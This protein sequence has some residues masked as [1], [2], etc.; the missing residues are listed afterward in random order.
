M[1]LV[2]HFMRIFFEVVK[3]P[4]R[5]CNNISLGS[6]VIRPWRI[7]TIDSV[8][9]YQ[10]VFLCSY[11]K[12]SRSPQIMCHMHPVPVVGFFSPVLFLFPIDGALEASALHVIGD[13][14][15]CKFYHRWCKIRIVYQQIATTPS[16][17]GRRITY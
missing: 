14:S 9:E 1:I 5:R 2:I 16:F 17:D 15:A 4:S 12:M 10:L 7:L 6:P 11:A 3:F 8:E 13:F